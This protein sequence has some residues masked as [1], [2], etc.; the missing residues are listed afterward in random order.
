MNFQKLT[1]VLSALGLLVIFVGNI[2]F[3]QRSTGLRQVGS[4]VQVFGHIVT[5][6]ALTAFLCVSVHARSRRPVSFRRTAVSSSV[7]A[8]GSV[9]ILFARITSI[10]LVV[11]G[12]FVLAAT[13]LQF[14]VGTVRIGRGAFFLGLYEVGF[15]FIPLA[16]GL[17]LWLIA[18][19]AH[20]TRILFLKSLDDEFLRRL[21]DEMSGTDDGRRA[22]LPGTSSGER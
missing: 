19:V 18:D 5:L 1:L 6:V 21:D 2:L 10:L 11:F 15:A 8:S 3:N 16:S 12:A 20:R 13:G 14:L 4:L 9:M 22:R 17:A 7:R